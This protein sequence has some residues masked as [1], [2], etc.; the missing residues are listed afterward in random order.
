[1]TAFFMSCVFSLSSPVTTLLGVL[2]FAPT[3]LALIDGSLVCGTQALNFVY[4]LQSGAP[5]DVSFDGRYQVVRVL[6]YVAAANLQTTDPSGSSP[7]QLSIIDLYNS[8]LMSQSSQGSIGGARLNGFQPVSYSPKPAGRVAEGI[9]YIRGTTSMSPSIRT[10]THHLGSSV[11][12]N[13]AYA[14]RIDRLWLLSSQLD[15]THQLLVRSL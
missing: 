14:E 6:L 7:G 2:C 15:S 8:L 5:I 3:A 1:M 9:H 4:C 10:A 13:A 12:N 11:V